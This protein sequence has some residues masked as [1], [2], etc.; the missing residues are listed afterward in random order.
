MPWQAAIRRIEGPADPLAATCVPAPPQTGMRSGDAG[1]LSR[2]YL[3]EQQA[4]QL[5]AGRRGPVHLDAK[6]FQRGIDGR[7]VAQA[8]VTADVCDASCRL[9][10]LSQRRCIE[11][12]QEKMGRNAWEMVPVG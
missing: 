7:E 10:R 4:D 3:T 8:V 2:K 6:S 9:G 5:L 1:A 12:L 11:F